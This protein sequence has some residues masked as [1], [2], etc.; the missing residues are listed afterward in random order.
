MHVHKLSSALTGYMDESARVRKGDACAYALAAVLVD[1]AA[2]DKVRD[3]LLGLRGARQVVLH[4]RREHPDRQRRMAKVVAEL[5]VTALAG[6]VLY[7]DGQHERARTR[8]L[9]TLLAELSRLEVDQ[10]ILESRG[11][12][13]DRRDRGVVTGLRVAGDLRRTVR[14]EWMGPRE[15]ELLWLPDIVAGAVTRWL[16]GQPEYFRLL[17]DQVRMLDP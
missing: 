17:A 1:S 16:D 3:E 12:A 9:K 15:Q 4:W 11:A 2:Q 5:P 6:V 10:V 13:R 7:N 8:C 14:V